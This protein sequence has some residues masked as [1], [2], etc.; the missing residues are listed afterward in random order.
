MEPEFVAFGPKQDPSMA[1]SLEIMHPLD[2]PPPDVLLALLARNKA[3]EAAGGDV[4]YYIIALVAE[5]VTWRLVRGGSLP[6]A[7]NIKS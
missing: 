3:L 7:F 6:S 4:S 2:P 1:S 5:V